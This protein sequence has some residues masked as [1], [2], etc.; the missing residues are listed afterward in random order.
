MKTLMN[1]IFRS[2]FG[3]FGLFVF[4]ALVSIFIFN[5]STLE[6]SIVKEKKVK[7]KHLTETAYGIIDYYYKLFKEG[8][9]SEEEAKSAA[10]SEIKALR[11]E[12]KEY[13]WINDTTLPFPKMVMHPTVPSLDGKVLDASKFNCAVSMQAGLDGEEVKTDGK[14]NL[15]QAM[16]EVVN[17]AGYGYVRYNWPKPLPSG[18]VTKE[19]YPKLSCVKKFEPWEWVIGTGVYID[20]V[21][22]TIMAQVIKVSIAGFIVFLIFLFMLVFLVRDLRKFVKGFVKDLE[23]AT[24]RIAQGDLTVKIE[25]KT[26]NEFLPIIEVVSNTIESIKKLIAN[27][28]TIATSLVSASEQIRTITGEISRNLKLQTERASQ[29]ASASEGMSQ[30][31]VDIAKNASQIAEASS[32][33]AQIAK[34][35][36]EVVSNTAQEIRLIEGVI[37]KLSEMINTLAERSRQIDEIVTVIKDIADQTNLL[38]L[39]AAIEAARAGEHGRGFAVV[40]DEVRKL[41]ERTT[42]AT[43]EIA[44]MISRIQSEVSVAEDSMEDATKKVESG[45]EL[46]NRSAEMLDQILFKAQE[47][48]GMIQQIASATEEMSSVT[49]NITQDIGSIAESSKKISLAVEQSAQIALDIARLGGELQSNIGKIKV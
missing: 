27:T 36:R 28:K 14:K 44:D 15:F 38:A 23:E 37:R 31:V 11:Y 10:I 40:A 9:L 18:G 42:R 7:L 32:Y 49:S 39:N 1:L 21:N 17:Q 3:I 25:A 46:S 45:V 41:A 35:G 30:T 19:S 26:K 2:R 6:D 33:T 8:K 47:L 24:N 22:K 13:F 12:E 48:Q 29:M 20:D 4:L 34:D 16:V 5:I 43:N